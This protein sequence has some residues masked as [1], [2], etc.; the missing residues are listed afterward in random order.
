MGCNIHDNMV[1]WVVVVDTP[2][3]GRSALP[4]RV[5]I[6]NVPAGSYR[7]KVWHPD[8][9]PGTPA[10]DQPLTIDAADATVTVRLAGV[11]P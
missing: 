1:A 9:R 3:Y 6:S 5:L 11:A 8:L 2:Y 10:G 7:L 4:G